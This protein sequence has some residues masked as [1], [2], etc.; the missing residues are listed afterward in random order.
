MLV[1]L[2]LQDLLQ[3]LVLPR[4]GLIHGLDFL[5]KRTMITTISQLQIRVKRCFYLLEFHPNNSN[6]NLIIALIWFTC[7]FVFISIDIKVCVIPLTVKFP[8]ISALIGANIVGPRQSE[9]RE[10][11]G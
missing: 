3:R 2:R 6:K 8:V 1:L 9:E 10:E 7:L 5:K 4:V 11:K